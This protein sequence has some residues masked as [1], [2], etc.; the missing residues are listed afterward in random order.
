MHVSCSQDAQSKLLPS[1]GSSHVE[2]TIQKIMKLLPDNEPWNA[3]VLTLFV[4]LN[5]SGQLK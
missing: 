3:W 5:I 2:T 4:F 1:R